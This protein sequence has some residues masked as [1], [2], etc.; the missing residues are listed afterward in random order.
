MTTEAA[1]DVQSP[2]I[3]AVARL[4]DRALARLVGANAYLRGRV[5]ARQACVHA[6]AVAGSEASGRVHGRASDPYDVKV[7]LSDEGGLTSQCSCP[8]WRGP[9]RHCKH[10]A[11]LLVALRDKVRPPRSQQQ[12]EG[13]E[14]DSS[15]PPAP[16]ATPNAASNN[17]AGSA[18]NALRPPKP[19]DG[20]R[21]RERER[22][23]DRDRH[24]RRDAKNPRRR[25][26][27]GSAR[28]V[29]VMDRSGP[30][31]VSAGGMSTVQSVSASASASNEQ[32]KGFAA[33]VPSSE[34]RKAPEI[35][36]RVH[37]RSNS[38][39]ITPYL[40]ESRTA[41]A[42]SDALDQL[43]ALPS[44]HRPILR[45]LARL[46]PKGARGAQVEARNEDAAELV[47]RLRGRR[48]L[49]EPMLMELRYLDEPLVPKI[50]LE[51]VPPSH[52][53]VR[54]VFE[55]KSGDARRFNLNQGLW[56]EGDPG[57][58][59]D[60]IQ[61][62]ARP[63]AD[64]VT[65]TWLERLL[66][67]PAVTHPTSDVARLLSEHLPKVSLALNAPL[68]DIRAIVDEIDV[69]PKFVMRAAGDL[70]R[71]VGTLD[72]KYGE[73]EF[74]VPPVEL[75][76]PLVILESAG[77]RPKCLRRDV[78]A[79]RLAVNMLLDGGLEVTDD[80]RAFQATEDRAVKFWSEC[81]PSLPREWEK[82]VPEHM[83]NVKVRSAPLTPRA[84]VSSGVDWLS[85]DVEF[86]SEGSKA[87]EE[88]LRRALEMGHKLVR[89]EDGTYA[90]IE[91]LQVAEVLSRL[92][93][94]YQNGKGQLPL[95]QAGRVQDLL[96]QLGQ[97]ADVGKSTKDFFAA[98]GEHKVESI[99]PPKDLDATM[100]PYQ[101]EG[102]SW[103]AYL[104]RTGTGGILADDM[105]LGKTLQAIALLLWVKRL[106]EPFVEADEAPRTKAKKG[107]KKAAAA[108]E[109][110]V[111]DDEEESAATKK[112]AKKGAK[113]AAKKGEESSAGPVMGPMAKPLEQGGPLALVV[114]PT[115]VVPNWVREVQKFAPA[116]RAIAWTGSDRAQ[117]KSEIERADVVVTSYALLRRD[118]E[119][120]SSID[121]GYVIL[122]EA[123]SI[124]NPTSATARAAK[125]LKGK[126]RLALTGTPIENRLSEIWSIFDFVSPGLLP[127]LAQFE[128][129]YA[130][131][132]DR[133][134]EDAA[135]RL[136]STIHPFVLRRTKN[137]V[138]QDLPEKI[139]TER[140]CEM[141]PE[142][143]AVYKTVLKSVRDTIMGEVEAN[144]LARSQLQILAG[145]TRLRQAACDPRLLGITGPFS[146]ET[147]GKLLALRELISEAQQGGHRTLV[148]SQFVSMLQLI[149]TALDQDGVTYEYIDGDTKDRQSRVDRFNKDEKVSVFL[150]SLKAGGTGLN[151]T[152]ADTVVHFDPWWNPAVEDQATDRA[153]RIGQTKVVTAYRF[154][155]RGT[156]EEK[157]LELSAKKRELVENVLGQEQDEKVSGVLTRAELDR[158][159]SDE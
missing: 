45:L 73:H 5:Y 4:S 158:L 37:V 143:L 43:G 108:K 3:Q 135:R 32:P 8:A 58:H 90:R 61:G 18:N 94:I 54:V 70:T 133:G 83:A 134:D 1:V 142:Q 77:V 7:N 60:P 86:G 19:K 12:G 34:P 28:E 79:E 53:R 141:P 21:E 15:A 96:S 92:Q 104:Y 152:G 55:R 16:N 136:R 153:H 44:V 47:A 69:A 64:H 112:G 151:L 120:L 76:P 125:N 17:N 149:K 81:V 88:D 71:V 72:V 123:Q 46:H 118:E 146:D 33:W 25:D 75:P 99:D 84:R 154:V 65:S 67:T 122:D 56:L 113:K 24:D 111:D 26:D 116:L 103:L 131:P 93:E 121:W 2:V 14:R 50:E 105:G 36:Y 114:A 68:P 107:A 23:R 40:A 115:S 101:Q 13:G 156:I 11:A 100:R 119:F 126:R 20:G 38:L 97:R 130:R 95:S 49:V 9:D 52:V 6:L 117:Y 39:A 63:L 148:F 78:G 57:W 74:Q 145:L 91:G 31:V 132:I 22:E 35:E 138:A 85:V 41:V 87:A 102:F 42:P 139:V 29:V 127:A 98:L 124:K 62:V 147:S 110:S 144:G 109:A 106:S 159:F 128:E 66:K 27:T 10:V 155:A 140:L 59:L 80:F 51:M 157:I 137:E 89:L 30:R 129:R 48:V 82:Y 150:I